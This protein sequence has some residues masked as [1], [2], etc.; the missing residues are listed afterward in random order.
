MG[1]TMKTPLG[2]D[3]DLTPDAAATALRLG[4]QSAS[5]ALALIGRGD[6]VASLTAAQAALKAIEAGA[7]TLAFLAR[8][9]G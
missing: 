3:M 7:H 1:N 5:N 4:W 9:H 6:F 8:V 2:A